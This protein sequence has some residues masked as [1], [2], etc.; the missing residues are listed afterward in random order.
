MLIS[1]TSCGIFFLLY[2]ILR[3]TSNQQRRRTSYKKIHE[4][5]HCHQSNPSTRNNRIRYQL[6]ISL[7][8]GNASLPALHF[9]R[10]TQ[11]YYMKHQEDK[12]QLLHQDSPLLWQLP[13]FCSLSMARKNPS[14]LSVKPRVKSRAASCAHISSAFLCAFP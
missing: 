14:P 11:T 10:N 6:D 2:E 1:A 3:A 5:Y 7:R 13:V 4:P 9:H 8:H 12:L